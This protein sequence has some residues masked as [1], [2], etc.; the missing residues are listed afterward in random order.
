MHD[1]Q[2]VSPTAGEGDP[3]AGAAYCRE[4]TDRPPSSDEMIRIAREAARQDAKASP[5]TPPTD[6]VP[7]PATS[8]SPRSVASEPRRR[9]EPRRAATAAGTTSPASSRARTLAAL[10]LALALAGL[11]LAVYLGVAAVSP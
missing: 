8:P 1:P 5:L 2:S 4:V 7:P 3:A 6:T 9:R 10:L 11:G